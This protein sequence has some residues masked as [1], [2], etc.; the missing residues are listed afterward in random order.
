MKAETLALQNSKW[1]KLGNVWLKN[2]LL[3][4]VWQECWVNA[5]GKSTVIKY[6]KSIVGKIQL[7]KAGQLKLM[8][9]TLEQRKYHQK[10][11]FLGTAQ[12]R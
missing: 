7:L 12:L 3:G 5:C 10:K 1:K 9:E 4:K 2:V 6:T 11:I 8:K